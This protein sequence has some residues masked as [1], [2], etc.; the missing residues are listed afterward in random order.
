MDPV[1]TYED[2]EEKLSGR[3]RDITEIRSVLETQASL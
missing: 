3:M 2:L 1:R